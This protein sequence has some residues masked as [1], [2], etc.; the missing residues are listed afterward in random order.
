MSDQK[1][2]KFAAI[3]VTVSGV[4]LALYLLFDVLFTVFLPFLL[5]FALAA[6][7]HPLAVR[8]ATR[9]G[10]SRRAVAAAFTLL[11]LGLLFGLAYVLFSRALVELQGFVSYLMSEG[12]AGGSLS[13]FFW[14][15]EAFFA[16]SPPQLSGLFSWLSHFVEDPETL[17]ADQARNWLLCLS[18][19]IPQLAMRFARALPSALLFLLVTVIACLYFSVEYDA[20]MRALRRLM[21][22]R[23]RERVPRLA[24]KARRAATQYLRAYCLL[25]LITLGE[26]TLGLFLLRVRYVLLMAL[27]IALLDFLPIFGVGT[28]LIPWAIFSLVTGNTALGV[29]LA[30]LYAVITVIRQVIEPRLVG[31]SLGV[32]PVLM[33]VAL[34]AGLKIFGLIGVFVGPFIALVAKVLLEGNANADLG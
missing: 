33:L 12:E 10:L 24:A 9:L 15:I 14:R 13:E 31:K 29:G 19:G 27:L 16:H 32:H 22:T 23:W 28:I 2:I 17:L 7:T 20:L 5:A 11:S 4:L 26:L 30:V 3:T 1:W 6:C 21:P 25:F 8:F 18:E 34:Y